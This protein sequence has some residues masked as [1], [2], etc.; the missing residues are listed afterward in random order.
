M[1]PVARYLL[2]SPADPR[3]SVCTLPSRFPSLYRRCAIAITLSTTPKA[4]CRWWVPTRRVVGGHSGVAILTKIVLGTDILTETLRI[5]LFRR[6]P[7]TR[8]VAARPCCSSTRGWH[9]RCECRASP[10]LGRL[11]LKSASGRLALPLRYFPVV[12]RQ[13]QHP[14]P[15]RSPPH[16]HD[17][18]SPSPPNGKVSIQYMA[19]K[20]HIGRAEREI[21]VLVGSVKK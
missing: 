5:C 20:N 6:R 12:H 10:P 3:N 8:I 21:L 14:R 7:I 16:A 9:F 4:T 1:S 2:P 19:L 11:G 17:D 15:L 13:L 18:A